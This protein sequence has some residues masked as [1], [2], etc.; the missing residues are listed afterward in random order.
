MANMLLVALVE[1]M[2]QSP[3]V[4]SHCLGLELKMYSPFPTELANTTEGE[5]LQKIGREFGATT[6]RKRRSDPA[7]SFITQTINVDVVQ[8][9]L[10]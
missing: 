6:G 7:A 5:T 3:H 2:K 8:V 4:F 1:G 10:A 9:W